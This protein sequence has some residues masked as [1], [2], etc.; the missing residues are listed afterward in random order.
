MC[1]CGSCK[2]DDENSCPNTLYSI[3]NDY[4]E[5]DCA[6]CPIAWRELI[7]PTSC[8]YCEKATVSPLTTTITI[9]DTTG[10]KVALELLHEIHCTLLA[11]LCLQY[12]ANNY[13]YLRYFY[14]KFFVQTTNTTNMPEHA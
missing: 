6:N 13:T 5:N 12:C 11:Q 9:R 4:A 10:N 2:P 7:C 14:I 8:N 3:C 1:T